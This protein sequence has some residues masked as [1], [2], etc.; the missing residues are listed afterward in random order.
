VIP[1]EAIDEHGKGVFGGY[2][3]A[4]W[5]LGFGGVLVWGVNAIAVCALLSGEDP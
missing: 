5:Q 3:T 4:V 1:A 2:D